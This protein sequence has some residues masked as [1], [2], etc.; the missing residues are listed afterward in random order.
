MNPN[1]R[2]LPPRRQ[3]RKTTLPD[4]SLGVLIGMFLAATGLAG[5]LIFIGVR[6]FVAELDLGGSHSTGPAGAQLTPGGTPG[7]NAG[8][9]GSAPQWTGTDRVTVLVTGIDQRQ[10]ETG[11]AHTDSIMVLSADPLAKTAV[12]FSIPRD[13][14]V[15]IPLDSPM[16]ECPDH[17]INEA[18]FWG[19][20]YDY[21]GGGGPAL[22]VETVSLNFGI[23]I[24]Y[25]VRI[26]FVAFE[27]VVDQIGGIDVEVKE[28]IDDPT[29]PDATYGYEPFYIEAGRQ[30]L[31][32]HDALRYART[33]ATLG[34]DFER[35]A[36][37]QQ[38]VL[39]VRDKVLSLN[40]MPSLVGKAPQLY[41]TLTGSYVTNMTLN[42]MLALASL[43]SQIPRENIRTAVIDQNYLLTEYTSCNGR[44]LLV[45][46]VYKI[47]NELIQPLFF[48]SGPAPH[49]SA[50]TGAAATPGNMLE[51]ATVEGA[52]LSVQNGSNI[53]GIAGKVRDYLTA[54]GFNVVEIGNADRLDYPS[55]VIIDYS[56]KA[57]T[58]RYL[59]ETFHVA[60]SNIF[61]GGAASP[62]ADVR[63]IIGAD[64]V[65]PQ[66]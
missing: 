36:R 37:Q 7:A 53:L 9:G 39:A 20:V 60:G 22:A 11:P 16:G 17:S 49:A 2:P 29:Y 1:P 4:W 48:A 32:G 52:R 42:Q 54:R 43:A 65:L 61:S 18:N 26:N 8:G 24:N 23:P 41:D 62:N 13:L 58:T 5:Y 46:D 59:A 57:Q 50:P 55:T 40:M 25:Y 14:K 31:S 51:L 21:P 10:N 63:V 30:H 35:A 66:Q 64:F 47:G 34:G 38:V 6:D 19:D 45:P 12:M 56:G 3:R 33:R 27:T 44:Q 28:T 15:Q